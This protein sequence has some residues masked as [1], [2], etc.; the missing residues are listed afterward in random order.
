MPITNHGLMWTPITTHSLMWM[1]SLIDD[2]PP[3]WEHDPGCE[4]VLG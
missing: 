2:K 4:L 3:G 1:L